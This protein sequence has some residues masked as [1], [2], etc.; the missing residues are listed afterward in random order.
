MASKYKIL[1]RFLDDYK[2][3]TLETF[4]FNRFTISSK[5]DDSIF[6]FE[7]VSR[8]YFDIEYH[9]FISYSKTSKMIYFGYYYAG[10]RSIQIDLDNLSNNYDDMELT[11]LFGKGIDDNSLTSENPSKYKIL[12]FIHSVILEHNN[13]K[14]R[15]FFHKD[16]LYEIRITKQVLSHYDFFIFD[17]DKLITNIRYKIIKKRI[18]IDSNSKDVPFNFSDL[19]SDNGYELNNHTKSFT[20]DYILN[21][22]LD[23]KCVLYPEYTLGFLMSRKSTQK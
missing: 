8:D 5:D 10:Y 6:Y 17:G 21:L 20:D 14:N 15:T 22:W 18:S 12:R 23:D 2:N 13:T 1:R 3:K 9:S 19:K 11:L 16:N 7:I 4:E